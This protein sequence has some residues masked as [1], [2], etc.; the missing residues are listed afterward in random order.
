M[1]SGAFLKPKL[2]DARRGPK[3]KVQWVKS[4]DPKVKRRI[5]D[6]NEHDCKAMRVLLDSMTGME[7]RAE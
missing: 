5:L 2:V 1:P 3:N 6:Y 4:Q 7:A